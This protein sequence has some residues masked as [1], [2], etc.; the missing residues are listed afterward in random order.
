MTNFRRSS[1]RPTS[2]IRRSACKAV[3]MDCGA[4]LSGKT[5]TVVSQPQLATKLGI[6]PTADHE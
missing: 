1:T 3:V 6:D 2:P 4:S 5:V